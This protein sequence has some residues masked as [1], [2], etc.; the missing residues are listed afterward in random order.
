MSEL[1]K[2]SA[3]QFS[4]A[5]PGMET[6]PSPLTDFSGYSPPTSIGTRPEVNQSAL[7]GHARYWAD[8]AGGS[9]EGQRA[10]TQA[11]YQQ[12][13][14]AD[15]QLSFSVGEVNKQRK[16]NKPKTEDDD[17]GQHMMGRIIQNFQFAARA[18][19]LNLGQVSANEILE[20]AGKG[21]LKGM[22]ES[23][24]MV[25]DWV[26]KLGMMHELGQQQNST[27]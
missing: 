7:D 8:R 6:P 5:Q 22:E 13:T 26:A 15:N 3:T 23:V 9:G 16:F 1:P 21:E 19:G 18:R 11:V 4:K 2:P 10:C 20:M 25:R 12:E 17:G 24:E 14:A 27:A